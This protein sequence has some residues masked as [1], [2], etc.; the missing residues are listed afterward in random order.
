VEADMGFVS[1]GMIVYS[2][3]AKEVGAELDERGFVKAD[4]VGHT[5]VDGFYVAGDVMA[6][7]KK[8]IYTAWDT[9]VNAL[10]VINQRL[11]SER[12]QKKLLEYRKRVN[13]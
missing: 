1:L 8:Q 13:G 6:G 5:T 4:S 3:L 10:D 9:A 11:R 12:R 7:T 2:D